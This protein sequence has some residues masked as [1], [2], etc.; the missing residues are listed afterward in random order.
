[1]GKS[2]TMLGCFG[3]SATKKGQVGERH[4][5]PHGWGKGRCIW[6]HRYLDEVRIEDRPAPP[7]PGSDEHLAEVLRSAA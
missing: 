2:Y 3:Y 7:K 6:C 4:R 5:W 1:M